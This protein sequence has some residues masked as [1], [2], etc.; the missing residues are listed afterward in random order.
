MDWTATS[1]MPLESF[2]TPPNDFQYHN[3]VDEKR[4][5][6]D[7]FEEVEICGKGNSPFAHF[8]RTNPCRIVEIV[9]QYASY[10]AFPQYDA[11]RLMA[12]LYGDEIQWSDLKKLCRQSLDKTWSS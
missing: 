8:M 1:A 7:I 9:D 6:I 2:L 3:F 11:E 4:R 10:G 5:F 12:L